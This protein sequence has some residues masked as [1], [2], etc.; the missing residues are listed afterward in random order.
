MEWDRGQFSEK[1]E[2]ELKG[3]E[4]RACSGSVFVLEENNLKGPK[5]AKTES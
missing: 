1:R 4:E 5:L 3:S 2:S